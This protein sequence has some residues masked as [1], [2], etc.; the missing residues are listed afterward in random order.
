MDEL[1]LDAAVLADISYNNAARLL[2]IG[3]PS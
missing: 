1:P 3:A 2:R